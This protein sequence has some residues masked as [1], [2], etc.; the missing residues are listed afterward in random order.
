[1]RLNFLILHDMDP[2]RSA[3]K[4]LVDHMKCFER[5]TCGAHNFVYHYLRAPISDTLRRLNFHVVILSTT[6]LAFCRYIQPRETFYRFK[7]AWS[8]IS[9]MD[10]VKLAFPQDDYHRSSEIDALFHAWGID[11]IYSVRPEY[12]D[13]LYPKCANSVAIKKI[14]SGYIDDK[15]IATM[16]P[17]KRPFEQ[18]EY[19][20][21]QR[22]TMHPPWG[23]HFSQIKGRM[24]NRFEEFG[25]KIGSLKVNISSR[26]EDVLPGDSWLKLLGNGRFA[27]GSECGVSLW[28]PEGIFMDRTVEYLKEHPDA[29]FEEVEAACFPGEDG[30]FVFSG[31]SPR[32]F[33]STMMGCSQVLTEGGYLG[34]L[35]PWEHYIPVSQDLHD[36]AA[37]LD[38]IEDLDGAK[39]RARACYEVLVDNSA[40]RY[41][42]LVDTVIKD[43]SHLSED[44]AFQQ[45]DP[46]QFSQHVSQYQAEQD[47]MPPLI[48]DSPEPS[49]VDRIWGT[50][51][52]S[53]R[54]WVPISIKNLL[55]ELSR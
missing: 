30:K 55:Y 1:M 26:P 21:V 33:E 3:R 28:D 4:S 44:R 35:E 8:F 27:L 12:K 50:V 49:I 54:K 20:I 19:D 22:V 39:R 25:A 23:G 51:P 46:V 14:M 37:A 31:V 16:E 36:V 43:I 41:H 34:L 52:S 40:F 7:D 11:V 24:A 29:S 15:S 42:A 5:Y 18:R 6:C 13:I 32:V 45:T 53:I 2:R 48:P 38:A 47:D 17:F 9:E 10:A